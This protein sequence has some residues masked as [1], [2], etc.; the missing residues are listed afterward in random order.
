MQFRLSTVLLILFVVLPLNTFLG[1]GSTILRQGQL[2]QLPI[3]LRG[4][5]TYVSGY[6]DLS[7][8][9]PTSTTNTTIRV[10]ANSSIAILLDKWITP[11]YAFSGNILLPTQYNFLFSMYGNKSS[12]SLNN[13]SLFCQIGYYRNNTEFMFFNS[14]RSERLINN[15]LTCMLWQTKTNINYSLVSGDRFYIKVFMYTYGSGIFY[16]GYNGRYVPSYFLDPTETRYFRNDWVSNST[17]PTAY[18]LTTG[19]VTSGDYTNVATSDNVYL[20][21]RGAYSTGNKIVNITFSG[22]V[23]ENFH[24]PTLQCLYEY[25]GNVSAVLGNVSWFNYTNNNWDTTAGS[26][27]ATLS[28]PTSD[29]TYYNTALYTANKY[30]STTGRAWKVKFYLSSAVNFTVSFDLVQFRTVYYTLLTT[31]TA[32]IDG[33]DE[34][35]YNIYSGTKIRIQKINQTYSGVNL[36]SESDYRLDGGSDVAPVSTTGVNEVLIGTHSFSGMTVNNMSMV[37]VYVETNTPTTLT[38][39]DFS[40]GGKKGVF[41]TEQFNDTQLIDPTT[42]SVYY[43]FRYV[44]STDAEYFYFGSSTRNSNIT[45]FSWS[46]PSGKA[47]QTA[48]TFISYL[49]T[50]QWNTA[51]SFVSYLAT[52]QWN[53][54]LIFNNYLA[55]RQWNIPINFNNY[56]NVRGWQTAI[57][58][59]SYLST[60]QWNTQIDFIS[61]LQTRQWNIP[62]DFNSY[63]DVRGWRNAIMFF[64]FLGGDDFI[65]ILWIILIASLISFVL[66]LALKER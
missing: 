16:F 62:L 66:Y 46:N 18:T 4:T 3:Y 42:W 44:V 7:S 56:L 55:T 37:V 1:Y 54:A 28:T 33:F 24:L 39:G 58:F 26:M 65:F 40:L 31:N 22:I 13:A 11:S 57:D 27:Y 48:I 36:Q 61:Y 41:M 52:R 34:D 43:T 47:W 12:S 15:T 25:K 8:I 63:L 19:T 35:C 9:V 10:N 5:S 20:V 50:R 45:N 59:I 64:A 38:S 32:S 21:V 30:T 17:V 2:L 23:G 51:L 49:V 29:T 14:S 60:R 6:K 53:T